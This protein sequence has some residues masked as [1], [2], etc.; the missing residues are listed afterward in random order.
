MLA[1]L[2]KPTGDLLDGTSKLQRATS[3]LQWDGR[4]ISNLVNGKPAFGQELGIPSLLC[5]LEAGRAF[6]QGCKAVGDPLPLRVI[7]VLDISTKL[8]SRAAA[9]SPH[10]PKAFPALPMHR[11]APA[12]PVPGN[13][14]VEFFRGDL[15]HTAFSLWKMI[16]GTRGRIFLAD[17][18]TSALSRGAGW[19]AEPEIRI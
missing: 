19:D 11:E 10:A 9:D 5:Q 12:P 3:A 6:P 15:L 4:S 1:P 2:E 13:L 16:Q 18:V 14:Q 7:F 17:L 8:L